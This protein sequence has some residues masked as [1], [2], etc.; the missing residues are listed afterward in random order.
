MLPALLSQ[1]INTQQVPGLLGQVLKEIKTPG[2]TQGQGMGVFR[3]DPEQFEKQNPA[4][5]PTAAQPSG[6]QQMLEEALAGI[7][8]DKA[9]VFGQLQN[10]PG[11]SPEALMALQNSYKPQAA[12][13][14]AGRNDLLALLPLLFAP[15]RQAAAAYSGGI[16]AGLQGRYGERQAQ[17]QRDQQMAQQAAQQ[18]VATEEREVARRRSNLQIQLGGLQDQSE[19]LLDAYNIKQDAFDRGQARDLTRTRIANEQSVT[20]FNQAQKK[21]AL[22]SAAQQGLGNVGF[23]RGN[24]PD[25]SYA[26]VLQRATGYNRT[27]LQEGD[28]SAMGPA[29]L[30]S[31]VDSIYE[32]NAK[33]VFFSEYSKAANAKARNAAMGAAMD[34]LKE[35][36]NIPDSV[37]KKLMKYG[38][39]ALERDVF[40]PARDQAET[41][42]TKLRT[43]IL[44][45]Y[46]G[47]K[48]REDINAILQRIAS[49]KSRD[50]REA[51]ISKLQEKASTKNSSL[52]SLLGTLQRAS[53]DLYATSESR[54][55][56]T[57]LLQEAMRMVPSLFTQMGEGLGYQ[58][59]T[60]TQPGSLLGGMQGYS[61]GGQTININV[62]SGLATSTSAVP[63]A[64]GA[65]GGNPNAGGGKPA[66]NRLL[67]GGLNIQPEFL[68]RVFTP[69]NSSQP[70]SMRKVQEAFTRIVNQF[71]PQSSQAKMAFKNLQF[72]LM[73]VQEKND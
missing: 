53:S 59:D 54:E 36:T 58:S 11:V 5:A 51:A 8:A 27:L 47:T 26:S 19:S 37:R 18:R 62:P 61:Q 41:A 14:F 15:D 55:E 3:Q 68:D 33:A 57:R 6:D 32:D 16:A 21:Q 10:L 9:G 44:A 25:L 35:N 7:K 22:I 30:K 34:R 42:L 73:K 13:Q 65:P 45:T 63:A 2:P 69:P 67:N 20:E 1:A 39:D 72:A 66:G 43:K 40:T 52:V 23:S 49:S 71:G 50:Q 24:V 56:A 38:Q 48:A 60:N 64:P 46:G 70:V 28:P 31:Y 29:E 12:P 17:Q 4:P